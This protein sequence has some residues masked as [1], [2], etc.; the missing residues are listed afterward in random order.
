MPGARGTRA[1]SRDRGGRA[2]A[3]PPP[4][5]RVACPRRTHARPFRFSLQE[6]RRLADKCVTLGKKGTLQARRAAGSILYTREAVRSL[7]EEY[8]PLYRLR[9]GGYTRVV[10]LPARLSDNAKMAFVEFVDRE[11]EL[12]PARPPNPKGLLPPS[13]AAA[14]AGDGTGT[15]AGPGPGQEGGRG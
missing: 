5:A 11:G 10:H 13:A 14:V 4:R 2:D 7:F 15:A 12:Y 8:A 1:H 6:L 3:F 9:Q